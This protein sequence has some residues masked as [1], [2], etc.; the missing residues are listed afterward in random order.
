[1][2]R[3]N[4]LIQ[5]LCPD[6]V[7]YVTLNDCTEYSSARVSASELDETSFVGVDNLLPNKAGRTD[8][9]HLPNSQRL[10]GFTTDDLLI[11]NIRPY[12]KKIWLADRTGGCSGDVL[13]IHIQEN[14]TKRLQPQYLYYL[15]SSNHFFSFDQQHAKGG[16][17]PRGSKQQVMK[18]RIPIPPLKV[19]EEIVRI[20][21]SFT[22]LEAE[23]ETELETRQIQYVYYRNLI[24]KR[25]RPTST[26]SLGEI[27]DIKSGESI[28]KKIIQSHPGKYPVINSGKKPL[29]FINSFNTDNNPIG[30]TSRGANVG[31]ITWCSGRYFRGNLNYSIEIRDSALLSTRYLYHLLQYLQPQIRQL[32]SY[33]GIPAL[34]KTKLEEL[35]IPLSN[36][37]QQQQIASS[38][39]QFRL[40][41]RS[42]TIGLQAEIEARHKQYEYYRDRLLTFK[43]L[44][45]E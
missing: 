40:M 35:K 23:L 16:K 28:S 27:T 2:S 25:Q 34:N 31:S 10:T 6:G 26:V 20:L 39:D 30:I 32:C 11:G 38:L 42:S 4:D 44:D 29:G 45:H 19:Q 22:S 18:Y 33:S 13:A 43:E 3:I 8:A 37:N 36:M 7:R 9:K 24:F 41:T 5:E 1:M 12:L 15:L 17:M 14:Y 21:D